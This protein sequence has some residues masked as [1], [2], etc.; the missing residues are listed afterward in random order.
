G[1]GYWQEQGAQVIASNDAE[2][3][4]QDR[5]SMQLTGLSTLI[6]DDMLAGTEPSP[7]DITFDTDY[8]LE[9]GGVTLQLHHEGAAHTPGD[10]TVWLAD[11]STLFAGDIVYVERILGIGPQSN[12]QEWVVSFEALAALNPEHIVPGHGNP[13][14]LATATRDTYDYLINI[15]TKMAAYIEDGGEI[16]DSVKIDQSAFS[17]LKN[18]EGLAG[19]NAQEVFTQMEWE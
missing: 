12:T 11:R 14:D 4:H 13:T 7:A 16:I 8:T 1:N 18:F 19:R 2:A 3:D 9:L 10:S 6:G 17:Y 15:R 5:A